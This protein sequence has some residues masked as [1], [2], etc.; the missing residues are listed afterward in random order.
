M[1]SDFCNGF[2][3]DTGTP[4]AKGKT[5]KLDFMKLKTLMLQRLLYFKKVK[6]TYRMRKNVQIMYLIKR[7]VP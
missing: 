5:D 6:K 4:A 2:L 7:L 1:T 3:H